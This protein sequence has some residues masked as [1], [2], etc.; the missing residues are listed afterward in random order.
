MYISRDRRSSPAPARRGIT[1]AD[2]DGIFALRTART[3]HS[4]ANRLL[5]AWLKRQDD[6]SA[7]TNLRVGLA[8]GITLGVFLVGL[9]VFLYTYRTSVKFYRKKKRAR[10]RHKSTSSK[11][12]KSSDG[13]A[14]P[15]PPPP[16]AE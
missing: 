9:G 11:S 1:A 10:H 14:P 8:V 16:A 15:Q 2:L 3:E 12:S 5:H 13:G 7:N 4:T 6:Q